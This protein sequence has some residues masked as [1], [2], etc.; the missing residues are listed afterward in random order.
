MLEKRFHRQE[1]AFTGFTHAAFS[2][3]FQVVV[4]H[5]CSDSL[6][7]I[8]NMYALKNNFTAPAFTFGNV[9]VFDIKKKGD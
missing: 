3:R 7:L 6:Q 8:V 2:C 1:L 5:V 9:V 4:L